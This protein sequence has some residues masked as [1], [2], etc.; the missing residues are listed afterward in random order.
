MVDYFHL[1]LDHLNLVKVNVKCEYCVVDVLL[2]LG[3]FKEA[4]R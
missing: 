3:H 4:G 1:D 2:E